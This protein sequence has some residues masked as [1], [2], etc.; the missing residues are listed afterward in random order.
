ML[1]APEVFQIKSQTFQEL[2]N[3]YYNFFFNF[4]NSGEIDLSLIWIKGTNLFLYSEI[5]GRDGPFKIVLANF[6]KK[7]YWNLL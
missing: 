2:C 1:V 7:K 6:F 4:Y 3:F 5:L